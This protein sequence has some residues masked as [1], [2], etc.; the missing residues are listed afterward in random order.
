MRVSTSLLKLSGRT[1][2]F[3]ASCLLPFA[4]ASA[5][6]ESPASTP[7]PAGIIYADPEL[8]PGT[9]LGG[10][11][12]RGHVPLGAN[13]IAAAL[14]QGLDEYRLRWGALPSVQVPA[15]PTLRRGASGP[16]VQALRERLGLYEDGGFDAELEQALADYRTAHGLGAGGIADAP[17]IRSLNRGPDYY[18][19]LI[20]RNLDRA[21][22]LPADLGRRFILVDTAAA[23]LWMYEDGR[24]V[25][26]M[27]VIVGRPTSQTPMMAAQVR[28]AVLNPYWNV[29]PDLVR[30]RIAP[31]VLS[32]GLPYLQARG[33][34]LLSGYEDDAQIVD[35]ETVDWTAVAAGRQE[36][37][38]R[39]RPGAG[40]MMGAVKYVLPNDFGIYLHDT[41]ER[42]LFQ[43]ADRRQSSGC[44]RL[45][46]AQRL[47][48]WLFGHRLTTVSSEP[49]QRVN[50]PE[51]V[52]VYITYF[53][54]APDDGRIVFRDDAY[55]RD[56]DA[57][58]ASGL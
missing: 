57:L 1:M 7:Q 46:D 4:T 44:I 30:E 34:E 3:T 35:P 8:A 18:E 41:P 37:V 9:A 40:N 29:P 10:A 17:T 24:P 56:R 58:A 55:G 5:A 2:A 48:T 27:R 25:D 22:A 28:Y 15:G 51:P 47:G 13:L 38:V 49:E 42:Q 26:S 11:K 54:A 20:E 14:E 39:Q 43:G 50:L 16:R 19:R 32:Q 53:T 36:I 6:A 12:G 33:Y 21:R 45:E 52:P 31:N 23:R